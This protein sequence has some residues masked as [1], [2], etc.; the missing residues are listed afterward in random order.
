MPAPGENAPATP[1]MPTDHQF[2]HSKLLPCTPIGIANSSPASKAKSPMPNS[3]LAD[4]VPLDHVRLSL[5]SLISTVPPLDF[6][7]HRSSEKYIHSHHIK[8]AGPIISKGNLNMVK[9][10]L[11]IPFLFV[12][13]Q[14]LQT[15]L[16]LEIKNAYTALAISQATNVIATNFLKL[17][18]N[19][20]SFHQ[21]RGVSCSKSLGIDVASFEIM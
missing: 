8:P 9:E 3:P 15:K 21:G 17:I 5:R 19:F 10:Q 11:P 6:P 20:V 16:T 2:T 18:F 1:D 14:S 12:A 13:F 7:S 4:P